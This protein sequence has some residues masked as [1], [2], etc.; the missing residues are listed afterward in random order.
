MDCRIVERDRALSITGM[1]VGEQTPLLGRSPSVKS[2]VM[3]AYGAT[4]AANMDKN[5]SMLVDAGSPPGPS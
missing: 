5:Q 1:S 3:E 4:I 2:Q